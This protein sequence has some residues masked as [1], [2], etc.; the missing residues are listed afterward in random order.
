MDHVVT[1][2]RRGSACH[3]R[4]SLILPSVALAGHTEI[5]IRRAVGPP[6][7]LVPEGHLPKNKYLFHRD[8]VNALNELEELWENVP[9]IDEADLQIAVDTLVEAYKKYK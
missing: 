1:T 4:P 8:V 6:G 9:D 5:R 7:R 3:S 2:Q